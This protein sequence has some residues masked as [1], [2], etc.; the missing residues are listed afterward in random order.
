MRKKKVEKE[1]RETAMG[2]VIHKTMAPRAA[3]LKLEHTR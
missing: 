2:L 1:E 3:Q